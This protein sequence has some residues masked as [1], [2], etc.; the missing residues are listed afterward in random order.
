MEVLSWSSI[1]NEHRV[2]FRFICFFSSPRLLSAIFGMH[3]GVCFFPLLLRFSVG[4]V[5]MKHSRA[6]FNTLEIYVS[7][8]YRIDVKRCANVIEEEKWHNTEKKRKKTKSRKK[9][10][11]HIKPQE[12]DTKNKNEK[13]KKRTQTVKRRSNNVYT[14]RAF[15]VMGKSHRWVL[16]VRY[17][18]IENVVAVNVPIFNLYGNRTWTKRMNRVLFRC[19]YFSN[20]KITYTI[21]SAACCVC[22][23]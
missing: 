16:C 8:K 2:S 10:T 14:K 5:L 15:E 12:T 9:H 7:V 11:N 21:L 3:G 18:R 4:A 17:I 23:S 6:K 20:G 19:V 13:E 22:V 1:F